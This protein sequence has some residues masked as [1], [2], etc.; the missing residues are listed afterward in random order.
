MSH[1]RQPTDPKK[2]RGFLFLYFL[3]L[4]FTKKYIFVLEIY[5]N[6][7][8][9]PR[10][11]AAGT[12]PPGSGAARAFLKKNYTKVPRGRSPGSGAAGPQAARAAG[13]PAS[14]HGT[15]RTGRCSRPALPH[16]GRTTRSRQPAQLQAQQQGKVIFYS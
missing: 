11:R 4:F 8:P 12:W 7:P 15:K 5:R 16:Q 3:F 14:H 1:L 13:R 10:C 6:I 2:L 9:P